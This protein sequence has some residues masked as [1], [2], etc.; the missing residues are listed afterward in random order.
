MIYIISYPNVPIHESVFSYQEAKKCV[1]LLN[2]TIVDQIPE[3]VEEEDMMKGLMYP[4]H[5][6]WDD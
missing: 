6:T 4:G 5:E 2:A 3:T 1:D